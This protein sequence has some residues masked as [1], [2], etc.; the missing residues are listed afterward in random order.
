MVSRR[1]FLSGLSAAAVS[2]GGCL[3]FGEDREV[4]SEYRYHASV[5]PPAPISNVTVRLPVPLRD[6]SVEF[7]D[8]LTGD[9]GIRPEDW[10]YAIV[11]TDRDPMLEISIETLEPTN[12]PYSIEMDVPSDAE[13]DTRD[14]LETEPTLGGKSNLQEGACDFPHPD[15][16]DDRLRCY[17]YESVFYGEYEPTGT[18]VAVDATF[19][20]EN[21]WF[22]G[23]WTGNDYTDFTHGFVDGTGW[24][25][26]RGSFREGVG[27]Y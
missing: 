24:V 21:S 26:G 10:S 25:S 1:T 13:I 7:A 9:E 3:G 23:G 5:N 19:V 12:R 15:E 14:A 4:R 2:I 27:R 11:T 8:A 18:S 6:G 22:N 16:W 20:G 17:T